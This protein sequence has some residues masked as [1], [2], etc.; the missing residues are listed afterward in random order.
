MRPLSRDK[1]PEIIFQGKEL[2][3]LTL[4][5]TCLAGVASLAETGV[6]PAL[7]FVNQRREMPIKANCNHSTNTLSLNMH[8]LGIL[9]IAA[10]IE[11][12]STLD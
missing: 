3:L 5:A 11:L 10:V 4:G 1:K 9:R 2:N 12:K 8:W 7:H 6:L